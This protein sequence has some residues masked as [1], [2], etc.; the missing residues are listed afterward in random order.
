LNLSAFVEFEVITKNT[1]LSQF[2]GSTRRSDPFG[3]SNS[4]L[5]NDYVSTSEH[6]LATLGRGSS[7]LIL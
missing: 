2:T 3:V 1:P 4:L 6:V 7:L 5:R